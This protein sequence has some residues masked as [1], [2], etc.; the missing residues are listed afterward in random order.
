M[1]TQNHVKNIDLRIITLWALTEAALGGLLHAFRIPFT[2][3]IVGGFA[4]I[5]IGL[6][7]TLAGPKSILK[8]TTI[9]ILIKFSIS[10]YTPVTAYLAVFLQGLI[11]YSLYSI[12]KSR[13]AAS[14]MLG[15]LALVLSA[16]QRIIII[17]LVF[18]QTFWNSIDDFADRI[19]TGIVGSSLTYQEF[20]VSLIIIS[21]YMLLHLSGGILF[22][23]LGYKMPLWIADYKTT[24][25]MNSLKSQQLNEAVRKKK[26]WYEK[27]LFKTAVFFMLGAF[28]LTYIFPYEGHSL[29]IDVVYMLLRAIVIITVWTFIVAPFISRLLAKYLGRKKEI[30]SDTIEEVNSLIPLFKHIAAFCWKETAGFSKLRRLK[31]FLLRVVA[32]SL[33]IDLSSR[34]Q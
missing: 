27:R 6:L 28:I 11:G 14:L 21:S 29:L 7:A 30:Y 8:A 33:T 3:L 22:G 5:Y 23:I 1:K 26:K 25:S 13:M 15:I 9:V 24:F 32:I 4:V 2:G 20:S 16:S 31:E 12:F 18:G 19:I 34:D 17:T 10:P